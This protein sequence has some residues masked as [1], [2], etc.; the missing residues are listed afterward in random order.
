MGWGRKHEGPREKRTLPLRQWE[1][2]QALLCR[3][4]DKDHTVMLIGLL[5]ATLAGLVVALRAPRSG[6]SPARVWFAQH[7]HWHDA[8]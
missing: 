3:Q 7:G 4:A 2:A 8:R 1:E 5:L 6:V